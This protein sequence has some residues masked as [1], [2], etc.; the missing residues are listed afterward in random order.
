MLPAKTRS[1]SDLL[2]GRFS[3]VRILSSVDEWPSNTIPSTEIRSPGRTLT[4]MPIFIST[5]DLSLSIPFSITVAYCLS[6]SRRG[7][8]FRTALARPEASR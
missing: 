8:T 3:P 6:A 5:M 7:A 2:T 1:P 4:F